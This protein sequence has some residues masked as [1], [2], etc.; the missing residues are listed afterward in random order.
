[1]NRFELW[2]K[3]AG[4]RLQQHFRLLVALWMTPILSISRHFVP[5]FKV[6]HLKYLRFRSF[7]YFFMQ[8]YFIT[9]LINYTNT[10]NIKI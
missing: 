9:K 1:M 4:C 6:G 7:N 10:C 5:Q 3:V 2:D 8:L